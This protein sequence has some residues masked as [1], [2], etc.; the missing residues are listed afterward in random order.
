[1][2]L[3]GVCQKNGRILLANLL[4][5]SRSTFSRGNLRSFFA[6][7]EGMLGTLILVLGGWPTVSGRFVGQDG[8][9]HVG[10][11]QPPWWSILREGVWSRIEES[12]ELETVYGVVELYLSWPLEFLR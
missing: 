7:K 11:T 4:Q 10:E 9:S 3:L 12:G 1:M 5:R 8:A 2:G 6:F